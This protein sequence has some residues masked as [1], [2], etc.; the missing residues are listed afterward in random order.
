MDAL[1]IALGGLDISGEYEP[2]HSLLERYCAIYEQNSLK[3]LEPSACVYRNFEV[4]GG[5]NKNRELT[6]EKGSLILKHSEDRFSCPTD[7][8]IKLLYALVRRGISFPICKIDE[9]CT[10]LNGRNISLKQSIVRQLLVLLDQPWLKWCNVTMRHS[11]DWEA[12]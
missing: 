6:L 4:Q 11:V 12:P 1:R 3:Y 7:S 10:A 2:A 5:G 9:F 8:E